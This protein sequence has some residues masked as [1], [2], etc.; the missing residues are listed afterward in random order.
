M[1]PFII[2]WLGAVSLRGAAVT[3]WD[4]HA[5]RRHR[6]RV[7]ERTLFAIAALGGSAAMYLT[8]RAIHHKTR[9]RRF[10]WGLPAIFAAQ[11][12]LAGGFQFVF[13]G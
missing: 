8:M 4:K 12:A 5:A 7:A 13:G 3:A 9:H 2:G 10:M 1:Y 6:R 11:L